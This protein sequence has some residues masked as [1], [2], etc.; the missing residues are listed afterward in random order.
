MTRAEEPKKILF[1][2]TANICRSPMAEEIFN[3]LAEDRML[4]FRA[5]SAGVAA[6]EGEPMAPK[7]SE[8]LEE[9]GIYTKGHRARQ[10][11]Q[12]ML[13]EADLVL[14]MTPRH[15]AELRRLFGDSSRKIYTLLEY[16]K[17]APSEEGISDP[18]GHSMSA[19]RTC[20]RQLFRYLDQVVERLER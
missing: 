1:V 17:R 19:F 3:A 7:A 18:Y 15:V 11:S 14:A 12:R 9:V 6:L 2:C 20:V 8:A 13:E 4:P 16:A 5:Q 10:V